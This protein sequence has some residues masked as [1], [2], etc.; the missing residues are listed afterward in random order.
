MGYRPNQALRRLS[1]RKFPGS[2]ADAA[3]AFQ[4]RLDASQWMSPAEI[5][6]YQLFHL[7]KL[8]QFASTHVE[9]YRGAFSLARVEGATRLADALAELPLLERQSLAA[10]AAGYKATTLPP[11]QSF[12]GNRKSSGTSGVL[13]EVDVTNVVYGWQSALSLRSYLWSG[14]DFDRVIAGLRVERGDGAAY[15][16]GAKAP[17]WDSGAVFPFQTGPAAHL[18]TAASL[19]QQWEWLERIRPDYLLTYP[20]IIR[21]FASRAQA[22][23]HG[24][25]RLHGI[26]TVGES[27]D[28]DLRQAAKTY[29]GAEIYDRYSSQECGLIACQCPSNRR[30]HVQDESVIVEI[31]RDD[32]HPASPGELGR[33][34]VTALHNFATPLI[35]YD[36]GDL[37][38]MGAP[39]AC[40]RGLNTINRIVGRQRNIFR[41]RGGRSFW[42]S[43]GVRSLSRYMTVRQHQFRQLDFDRIEVL[44]ATPTKVSAENEVALT[45]EMLKRLP[46]QM[47]IP[48]RYVDEIPRDAGGKYQ[49]CVCLIENVA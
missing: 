17:A 7:K 15:P 4:H 30:Y 45:A 46:E 47:L 35:R 5:D 18:T 39:C 9:A 31:L 22:E 33:V 21:A 2:E 13:V 42:P 29:L 28:S 49:E 3:M 23:R 44:V 8:A 48:F 6:A 36:I 32:G 11:G 25:C 37:A 14:W 41:L 12:S 27:I 16:E 19:E 34:V 26:A 1:A 40:G 24:P 20:S 38:E 10:N 43:F